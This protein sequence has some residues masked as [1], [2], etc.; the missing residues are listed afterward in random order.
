MESP[1]APLR[2]SV[3]RLRQLCGGLDEGQLKEASYCRDWTIAD[4]LS[5][6]GSAAVI[7]QR[8][9]EDALARAATPDDF[10]PSVWDVWN[11]K[12][13]RAQADDSL[14]ADEGVLEAFEGVSEADRARATFPMGPLSLSFDEFAGM[15]LNEHAFHTWDIEVVSDERARL[16]DDAVAVVVDNLGMIASFTARPTGDERTVAVRT[17]DPVREFTIRL[18][19]DR[20]EFGATDSGQEPDLVVPSEAFCRLVYGRLDPDHTP[21][22]AGHGE[23]LDVLRRVFPGP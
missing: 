18:T 10:A 15:R 17:T 22:Y 8:R 11:A 23:V 20:A 5:H 9:L 13:P 3:A 6:L 21:E 12:A 2:A 14:A 7:V 19:P 4:V 16:P 1:L